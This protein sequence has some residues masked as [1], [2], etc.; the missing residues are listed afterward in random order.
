MARNATA[1]VIALLVLLLGVRP[2]VKAM[3]KKKDEAE[4]AKALPMGAADGTATAAQGGA[5]RVDADGQPLPEQIAIQP[6]VT[7]DEIE[8]TNNFD[9]RIVKVRGFTR[10]NPARAALAI[11]DMIRSEAQS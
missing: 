8:E 10:D 6:A 1:L 9:D 3:T 5:P 7:L 2:L 4:A 11:R